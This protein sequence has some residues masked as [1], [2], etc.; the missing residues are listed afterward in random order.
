MARPRPAKS[1]APAT[2]TAAEVRRILGALDDSQVCRVLE[3]GADLV[4][5]QQAA[6]ALNGELPSHIGR[7][8]TGPAARIYDML[9]AEDEG[10]DAAVRRG[11]TVAP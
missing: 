2:P 4:E 10:D 5:L 7:P 3:T 11:P 9:S 1:K 8:I 6:A